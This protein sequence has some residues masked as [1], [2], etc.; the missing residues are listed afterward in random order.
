MG[1][2]LEI[3]PESIC[4]ASNINIALDRDAQRHRLQTED[5]TTAYQNLCIR[6][7]RSLSRTEETHSEGSMMDMASRCICRTSPLEDVARMELSSPT[8]SEQLVPSQR[9]QP[10]HMEETRIW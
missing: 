8:G 1:G 2:K 4:S 3:A 7:R 6:D 10:T 5:Q 9:G